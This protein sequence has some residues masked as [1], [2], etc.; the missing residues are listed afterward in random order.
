MSSAPL[1]SRAPL[2]VRVRR[3]MD[4]PLEAPPSS[5]AV[6]EG[7]ALRRVA[8]LGA[9]APGLRVELRV[10][11]GERVVT[12]QTLFVDRRR[13]EVRFTSPGTGRVETLARGARRRLEAL[14]IRLE[15]GGEQRFD[16]PAPDGRGRYAEAP[17]REAMQASGLWSA[18]RT[19]PFGRIP[20][21]DARA[22]AIFVTAMAS[23]AQAPTP[24]PLLLARRGDFERGVAALSALGDGPVFVCTGPRAEP[25]LPA[26][27]RVRHAEFGG[28]HPAGLPGTHIHM[29]A[30]A[31]ESRTVWHLPW[32]VVLEL[33]HLLA[34]GCATTERIVALAGPSLARPRLLRTRVGAS[35]EELL[36]GELR[37]PVPQRVVS[38]SL[39]SG[40]QASGHEAFLGRLHD[41]LAVLPESASPGRRA[42][43]RPGRRGRARAVPGSGRRPAFDASLAGR[44]GPFFPLERLERVWP[45]DLPVAPLL[46][47]LVVGDAEAARELG[48]LELVEEDLALVAF[49]CP[50]KIEYGPLLRA[51]LDEIE[52]QRP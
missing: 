38:G 51:A 10:E 18:L 11:R 19:R 13:P 23:D 27:D 47:A 8:L 29:L 15:G 4:L 2:R 48:A 24:G 35:T 21:P 14:V 52:R 31:G 34:T 50:G 6:E 40:R 1:P 9:D 26:L 49:L 22:H 46:R 45:F 3:G 30:P 33:G 36:A 16:V 7:P 39:L 37:G 17:L 12:G 5:E 32:T 44:R 25:P 42:W 43:L 28:P 20:D 41:Q